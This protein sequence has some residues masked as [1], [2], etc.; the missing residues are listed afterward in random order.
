M[1]T[2]KYCDH[3]Q[4]LY[5]PSEQSFGLGTENIL[6]QC[7]DGTGVMS[8]KKGGMQKILQDKVNREVPFVIL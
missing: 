1:A 4:T 2:R 7:Y 8:G 6:R 5:L 3:L